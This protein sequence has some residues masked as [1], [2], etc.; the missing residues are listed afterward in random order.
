M[1]LFRTY[2]VILALI[3]TNANAGIIESRDWQKIN[4]GLIT[5]VEE[6][7]LEWLDL[8]LT[9]NTSFSDVISD[10]TY[11]GWRVAS[12]N[13]VLQLWDEFYVPSSRMGQIQKITSFMGNIRGT[14]SYDYG[15]QGLTSDTSATNAAQHE[16]IGMLHREW[17]DV[18]VSYL[19]SN[20]KF[21]SESTASNWFGTYLVRS[22][23]VPEPTTLS[24][25]LFALISMRISKQSEFIFC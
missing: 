12:S 2:F 19:S 3:T 5:Y 14:V 23:Q 21:E 18:F 15:L 13:E 22:T 25:L 10:S 9:V 7:K 17:D 8:T 16:R 4:D 1:N 6:M 24:I 20:Y 11:S